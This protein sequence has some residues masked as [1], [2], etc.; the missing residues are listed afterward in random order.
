LSGCRKGAMTRALM[1]RV[2]APPTR[3]R[4]SQRRLRSRQRRGRDLDHGAPDDVGAR[5]PG[6]TR[7]RHDVL[8]VATNN[9]HYATPDASR[10]PTCSRPCARARAWKRWRVAQREP[11]RAPA[12]RF[13]QR[14]RFARWPGSSTRPVNWQPRWPSTFVWSRQT[15][16]PF[17]RP[18]M[19]EQSYLEELVPRARRSATAPARRSELRARGDRSITSSGHQDLA[20]PATSSRCGTSPS[21]VVVTTSTAGPRLGRELGGL[22]L[23]GHHERRRGEIE[24][25]F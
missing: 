9:V 23:L 4:A 19:D 7:V 5:R 11:A 22:F 8:L 18:G 6:R 25:V 17:R 13:E 20:S 10:A 1:D 21:S 3:T 16:R 2:L 12:Q 15:C 14:R 24:S